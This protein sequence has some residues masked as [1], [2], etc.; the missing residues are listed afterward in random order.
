MK[1]YLHDK[2]PS[3][4][5]RS[6]WILLAKKLHE[7]GATVLREECLKGAPKIHVSYTANP[8]TGAGLSI[9]PWDNH[10]EEKLRNLTLDKERNKKK[11]TQGGAGESHKVRESPKPARP[12]IPSLLLLA[13]LS[14]SPISYPN[15]SLALR[16]LWSSQCQYFPH[17]DI[18][19][20]VANAGQFSVHMEEP[21]DRSLGTSWEIERMECSMPH[22]TSSSFLL[23]APIWGH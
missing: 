9:I 1:K 8:A 23:Q 10:E 7:P 12:A 2:Q 15:V 3:I 13:P 18:T 5:E 19:N 21:S 22:V 11:E 4:Y 17:T 16:V 14:I 20:K 6:A